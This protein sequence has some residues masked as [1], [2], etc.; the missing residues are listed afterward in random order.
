MPRVLSASL[1][2]LQTK[3]QG[4]RAFRFFIYDI[5]STASDAVPLT[6]S[7]VVLGAADSVK[8]EFTDYIESV[9]IT[10]RGSD[11][12]EG[13][14]GG[15]SIRFRFID[16][17]GEFDPVDGNQKKWLREGNVVRIYEGDETLDFS[18]W[19]A[20]FTGI[21]VGR[22][23]REAPDRGKN[24][25]LDVPAED[26]TSMFL[27]LVS[28]SKDF[29]QGTSY[30]AMM[31]EL[32][33]TEMGLQVGEYEFGSVG[34]KVSD[35]ASTQFVD[36]SPLIS[37]ANLLFV[38]GFVPRFDGEGILRVVQLTVSKGN[39]RTYADEDLQIEVARPYNPLQITNSIIIKG[40]AADMTRIIQATQV[41]AKAGITLGFFGG[42]ASIKVVFS[43][44]GTIF[45][46]N[47]RLRIRSSV[48][49]AL[50]PFGNENFEFTVADTD[51]TDPTIQGALEGRIKVDGAFYAPLVVVNFAGRIAASF[52]PDTV[53]SFGAGSTIPVGRIIEG[54]IAIQ[55]AVV[56]AT[57]GRGD[58]EIIGEPYEYVFQELVGQAKIK[59]IQKGEE[60]IKTKENQLITSQSAVDAVAL[61]EL[62]LVRK[63][64]NGRTITMRHDLALEPDDKFG[65]PGG[66]SFI[67]TQ[68]ERTL[69][70]GGP[71]VATVQAFETTNGVNP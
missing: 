12:L 6:F 3:D 7:S 30:N 50:I 18:E 24:A 11:T 36:E 16:V 9:S 67:I 54:V 63:R 71:W 70:R 58:Y 26:R 14:I 32:A 41:V 31:V 8:K 57:I 4:R 29:P 52:I 40:L 56:Q 47:P 68:I 17:T 2:Q 5:R 39:T 35:H 37:I 69:A 28:T 34:A 23:G 46:N 33:K 61:R 49:G 64:G 1:D 65:L 48:T 44:D 27:K 10:E 51:P 60:R 66:K 43:D 42:D 45:V 62:R 22:A 13:T 59:N 20:T 15:N 19:V 25:I 38:D 53:A 55:I 21:I